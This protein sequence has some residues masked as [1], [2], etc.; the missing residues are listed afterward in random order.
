[1][2][3]SSKLDYQI[4]ERRDSHSC[5]LV[6]GELTIKIIRRVPKYDGYKGCDAYVIDENGKNSRWPDI[7]ASNWFVMLRKIAKLKGAKL[8]SSNIKSRYDEKN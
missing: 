6:T 5:I 8:L 7:S 4:S 1:M 2:S 3:L